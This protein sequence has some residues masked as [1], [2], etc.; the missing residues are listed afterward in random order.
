MS[1]ISALP[2]GIAAWLSE[3]PALAGIKFI[4]QFPP[5]PKAVPLK[6]VTVSAGIEDLRVTDSFTENDEG[7]LVKNEYCRLA[8]IKLSL[9][10]H[11]PFAEGG[12]KC[13]DVFTDIID[14][15]TF[16]SDLNIV[17]SGCGSV[18][19]D[20]NTDAL[21]LGTWALVSASLCPADGSSVSFGSFLNKELLCGS[22][23]RDNGIHVT[24]EDKV[25]W[26]APFAAGAYFG[27]G[28]ASRVIETGFSPKLAAV[29]ALQAPAVTA[30]FA[31]GTLKSGWGVAVEGFETQGIELASGGFRFLSGPSYETG[32]CLPRLNEAGSSYFY[33][34]VK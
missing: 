21:V 11:V 30:D 4:T 6:K 19:S 12:A 32:G 3:Q 2:A 24:P 7:V 29:F 9:D 27:T 23:I 18:R 26:N 14:C 31:A 5:A 10:I 8:S 13:H 20:R 22:H 16:G 17:E 33:I 34:A 25:L 15:L 28:T 1:E